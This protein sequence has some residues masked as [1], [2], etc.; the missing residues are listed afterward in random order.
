MAGNPI[1]S[2]KQWR[3]L[4][5]QILEADSD[6]HWCRLKGKRV[7]A[8]QVD[9]VIEIDAGIDPYDAS[10]LVPSC[11]SC[12]SSRGAHYVNRKTAQ[13][14]QNRKKS[15]DLSFFDP[16][17]TPSPHSEI[18]SI[19]QNQPEP[20]RTESDIPTSGRIEPRLVTPVPVGE[21]FGPALTAWAKRVLN[22]DLMEWQKRIVNDALTL[23]ENGDF[24]FREACVSTARQC[25]KSLVMRACAG[26]FATEY[27]AHRK[28]PQT[29]V[30]VANQKRR[31]MALFRDV[32]RDLDEKFECK[33][34]WQNGDERINFPDGSSISVVAAS[35]HAHGMT[36][37]HLLVD[38]LWDIS[39]EVVFTAL[40]PSQIAVKNP[41]MMMFST[42]G[43]QSS[44][45]LLQLR[46]QGMAAIDSGRTGSLYF[47][48]WSLPPDVSVEDRRYWGWANPALGTTIT[49]KALE[50]AYDSPN[51]QSFVRG[52]LNLWIDSNSAWLPP[53]WSQRISD[54][55][56]PAYQWI[57]IDSSIDESRYVG[58]GSAFDGDRVIVKTAFV[59]ESSAQMWE[60]VVRIMNDP[61]VKLACTPSLEIHCPPDLRRRMTIVGYAELLKWTASAKA[62]IVEDRCR[63]TGDIALAEHMARA[64]AVKTGGHSVVLS[65]QKSPGPIELARCAVWGMMLAS[66]P[67]TRAKPAMA[68]G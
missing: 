61:T 43:D 17:L 65:S 54:H 4:R 66:K 12:N 5:T 32:V 45:V 68:F 18:P 42:A 35:A 6:C 20:A 16:T 9:H 41:M 3:Q 38:E 39:P 47:A 7:K 63:H 60:Q 67:T 64:V 58:I 8:T 44:T 57:T 24:I 13:R 23:D 31:S 22:I 40:R 21:S 10:N 55:E 36:A 62:M 50:L 15:S 48:E 37:T 56:M 29:I 19:S 53:I 59:V 14:I 1:Y 11:A 25:G 51:R 30:I 27:A 2:T 52:H 26:F 28:E 34:R 46:E 33:V 49:M